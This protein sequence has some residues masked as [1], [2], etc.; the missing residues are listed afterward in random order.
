MAYKDEYE[1]ARLLTSATF[2]SQLGD[3]WKQGESIGYNLHP[4]LLRAL[5]W[6][7]KLQLGQWFGKPLRLLAKMKVLRGSA[8]D[9]FGYAA[10]RREERAL[11]VWYRTLIEECLSRL[12]PD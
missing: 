2:Q 9:P 10:V 4:P 7:K 1:V 8:L 11:I 3:M 6:K 12:T 5:G